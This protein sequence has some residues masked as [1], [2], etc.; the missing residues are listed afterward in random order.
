MADAS[1]AAHNRRYR[2]DVV[3][4]GCVA[5][6][7]KKP[8]AMMESSVIIIFRLRQRRENIRAGFRETPDYLAIPF[9]VSRDNL[10]LSMR[11]RSAWMLYFSLETRATPALIGELR[12]SF[13]Q[14]SASRFSIGASASLVIFAQLCLMLF[15]LV[16]PNSRT[17]FCSL[18]A[19]FHPFRACSVPVATTDSA[20]RTSRPSVGL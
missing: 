14:E 18:S 17:P 5:H 10:K 8:R 11:G 12:C 16:L 9:P 15:L 3:R 13:A 4:I 1:L 2:D 20:C 6:A 19:R 7:R